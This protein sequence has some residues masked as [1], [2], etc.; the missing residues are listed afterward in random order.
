MASLYLAAQNRDELEV[1]HNL[2]NGF[3]PDMYRGD[4]FQGNE[5]ALM[6]AV[7]HPREIPSDLKIMPIPPPPPCLGIVNLLLKAGADINARDDGDSTALHHN[8]NTHGISTPVNAYD[9][10]KV[11]ELLLKSGADVN[12]I[13]SFGYTPL[14]LASENPCNIGS[15]RLLLN[16]GA[17]LDIKNHEE[18]STA[19]MRAAWCDNVEIAE[20][21]IKAGCDIN[22]QDDEGST[23]LAYCANENGYFYGKRIDPSF[24]LLLFSKGA[25]PTIKSYEGEWESVNESTIVTNKFSCVLR[26]M[27]KRIKF[28]RKCVGNKGLQFACKQ[29]ILK[30]IPYTTEVDLYYL[31]DSYLPLPS[32][33]IDFLVAREDYEDSWEDLENVNTFFGSYVLQKILGVLPEKCLLYFKKENY[34]Y[35]LD[36]CRLSDK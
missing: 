8:V 27:E 11:T 2:Q 4:M 29:T 21:L 32:A 26:I 22:A 10:E 35:H 31:W 16:S 24:A 12:A 33:L 28:L 9:I 23:A 1:R 19:L 34:V 36:A 15:I 5:T 7:K 25:D 17:D 30:N 3:H 14:A 13:D 18:G 20:E 6:A